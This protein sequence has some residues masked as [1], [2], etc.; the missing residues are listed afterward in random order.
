MAIT[1]A[2][3]MVNAATDVDY[4]VID[5]MRRYDGLL[6]D[7]FTWDDVVNPTGGSSLVY[8]YTRLVTPSSA[9]TRAINA[10]YIPQ[11]ATRTQVTVG[12]KQWGTSFEL[13]R[14]LANLGQAQTNELNFQLSQATISTKMK[15]NEM[16]I[17]GDTAVDANGFD[18]LSKLLTG[19]TTE[20]NTT[21]LDITAATIT[22]QALAIAALDRLDA[23]LITIFASRMGSGQG[24]MTGAVP[25]GVRMLLVNTTTFL[26]LQSII[27]LAGLYTISRDNF[28]NEV[29][30]Y[31]GWKIVNL[32]DL[33]DGTGPIIPIG[34]SVAGET[35]IYAVSL[36]LD[37]LHGASVAGK[38]LLQTFLPRFDLPGAVKF[39][40]LEM[41]PGALVLKS[42]KSAGVFRKVKVQ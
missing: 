32:G 35:E 12:L 2:Q 1:L 17:R 22:T 6:I 19:S 42:T 21:T 23:W 27:R 31:K 7:N 10:E 5:D 41:G 20:V 28:D 36:G 24:T 40:E 9:M 30:E 15:F 26:R 25:P 16:V 29:V 34:A 3:A 11:K 38:P 4:A 14:V 13:D 33:N 37:A 18:G 39:G 8:G